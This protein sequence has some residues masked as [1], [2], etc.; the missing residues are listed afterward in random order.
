MAFL[1]E[2]TAYFTA[3]PPRERCVL[4]GDLNVAPLEHDVWSHKQLRDVVSHTEPEI[5]RLDAWRRTGFADA[6]RHLVPADRKLYTWWSYRNRDWRASDRGR[7][8]D[9]VWCTPD[10]LPGLRGM[11]VLKEVRDWP[12]TSDHVPV[13][14]DFAG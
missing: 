13:G 6:M 5:L 1:D 14:G 3:I 2:V 11:T 10:L 12:T 7:R 9:H 4:V 8:L